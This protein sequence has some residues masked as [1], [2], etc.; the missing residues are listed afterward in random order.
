M[1]HSVHALTFVCE[2]IRYRL[3]QVHKD[4]KGLFELVARNHLSQSLSLSFSSSS[5]FLSFSKQKSTDVCVHVKTLT[6]RSV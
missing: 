2:V 5:Y 4:L 3:A 1:V 6:I